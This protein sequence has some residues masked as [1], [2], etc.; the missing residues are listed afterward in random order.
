MSS[1]A[2]LAAPEL[3]CEA[4]LGRIG[5]ENFPV[6]LRWLPRALRSDLVAI[7]G[8]ARLIDEAGDAARGDRSALL[9]AVEEDLRAAFAGEA[10]HPLLRRLT[11]IAA[12]HGL[13]PE[14]F[15]RLIA[16]NRFDQRA[17]DLASWGALL[18]YCRL[19]ANPVGELVLRVFDQA[20]ADN[21]RDSDAVCTALQ[22]LE[23]CQDVAED[24]RAGRCYLP[25]DDRAAFGVGA[26]DLTASPAP[27]GLR[28]SIARQVERAREL[29]V[30]GDALCARLRGLARPVVAGYAA[31]GWAT[32][33]ALERAGFD[34]NRRP[35]RPRRIATLRHALRVGK[36][37]A[38]SRRRAKT[39]SGEGRE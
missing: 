35:V 29:L 4:V 26:R 25:A 30:H 36:F 10:R 38:A 5:R 8:A 17:P 32:A 23:H 21:L 33:A 24:A 1:A 13:S 2:V 15:V 19:S 7:Y 39:S 37:R 14:P 11:P 18:D 34:P 20:S 16:A 12:V 22:V 9:D 31:G 3:S 28:R 27:E 6:A